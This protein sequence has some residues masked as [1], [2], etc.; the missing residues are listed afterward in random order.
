MAGDDFDDYLCRVLGRVLL[1]VVWQG[2][3]RGHGLG[4][5]SRGLCPL[6]PHEQDG[7]TV[8]SLIALL[9]LSPFFFGEVKAISTKQPK[10]RKLD[11]DI[12]ITEPLESI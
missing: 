1:L 11:F 8:S 5:P 10:H 9:L 12:T 3:G 4:S 2:R 6:P 7:P